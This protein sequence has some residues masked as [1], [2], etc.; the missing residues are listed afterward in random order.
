MDLSTSLTNSPFSSKLNQSST[1][2]NTTN[3]SAFQINKPLHQHIQKAKRKN[4]VNAI[5]F[6]DESMICRRRVQNENTSFEGSTTSSITNLS[7]FQANVNEANDPTTENVNLGSTESKNVN[8]VTEDMNSKSVSH[9]LDSNTIDEANE[10]KRLF[11]KYLKTQMHENSEISSDLVTP[12]TQLDQRLRARLDSFS[13]NLNKADDSAALTSLPQTSLNDA[14]IENEI[15]KLKIENQILLLTN[16]KTLPIK[17]NNQKLLTTNKKNDLIIRTS[18]NATEHFDQKLN[19]I[20]NYSQIIEDAT[21]KMHS[22]ITDMNIVYAN[23]DEL[24]KLDHE[25]QPNDESKRVD[26]EMSVYDMDEKGNQEPT[27]QERKSSMNSSSQ[28]SIVI[29]TDTDNSANN[30]TNMNNRLETL[31]KK[32]EKSEETYLDVLIN[33]DNLKQEIK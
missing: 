9:S 10:E 3:P 1:S 19:K 28:S 4:Q 14:Q 21:A 8:F 31:N 32:G 24:A 5:S 6:E 30:S 16:N 11:S 23:D 20:E 7:D 17:E 13:K 2:L 27:N 12:T 29:D 33:K 25:T 26:N 22:F 15:D 18:M